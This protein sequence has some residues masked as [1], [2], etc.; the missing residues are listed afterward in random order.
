[1][2]VLRI[3]SFLIILLFSVVVLGLL[4]LLASLA[5]RILLGIIRG[6]AKSWSA[7]RRNSPNYGD[8]NQRNSDQLSD[9][10]VACAVCSTYISQ[11][12]AVQI[13]ST[14]KNQFNGW[15]CKTY[16]DTGQVCR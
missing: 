8:N 15:V 7:K 1:M 9:Q 11:S 16:R 5:L 2:I 6:K 13:K 4:R 14:D 3:I 12:S 10:L